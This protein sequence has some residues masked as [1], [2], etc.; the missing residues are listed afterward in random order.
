MGAPSPLIPSAHLDGLSYAPVLHDAPEVAVEVGRGVVGA[1]PDHVAVEVAPALAAAFERAVLRLPLCSA[2]TFDDGEGHTFAQ[3]VHPACPLAEAVR[4]AADAGATWHAVD[5]DLPLDVPHDDRLPDPYAVRH[6]GLAGLYRL[7][8]SQAPPPAPEP[9]DAIREAVMADRLRRLV[10]QGPTV[11]V[12]GWLHVAGI[13]RALAEHTPIPVHRARV[14]APLVLHLHPD[15]LA[16]VLPH[17]PLLDALVELRR[18]LPP[19]LPV[20]PG[21]GAP[22]PAAHAGLVVL[23]G[24]RGAARDDR[25]EAFR[26][27]A[28]DHRCVDE[29]YTGVD[30]WRV[31][32]A[33]VDEA[34]R[35]YERL[36]DAP[37]A[38]WQRRGLD[39]MLAKLAAFEG[40]LLPD[41]F[42][43]LAAARGA[44]DDDFAWGL[45]RLADIHPWQPEEAEIPTTHLHAADLRLGSRTIRLERDL[46]RTIRRL[47]RFP[48]RRRPTSDE[49]GAWEAGFDDPHLVSWPPEDLTIEG[50]ATE[51]KRKGAGFLEA[52]EARVEPFTASLRDG[53]DLRETLRHVEDPRPWVREVVRHQG[54]ADAV[55]LIFARE[56]QAGHYPYRMTWLGEHQNESDMSF[57]STPP[58]ARIIGPGIARCE[59]G[60][61]MMIV[62]P[63]QLYDVWRIPEYRRITE[64][65]DEILTLAAL[66]YT[67]RRNVIHVAAQ[68]PSARLQAIARGLGRRLVHLP[69]GRFDPERIRRLR[70]FHILSG[71]ARRK[72]ARA[73]I[74]GVFRAR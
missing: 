61:L 11:A 41:L 46:R 57:Y 21:A 31:L 7:W 2:L 37:V 14:K 9:V 30:R 47:Q 73:Y 72:D 3:L 28:E 5:A 50:F 49:P 67:R 22:E 68:P 58:G 19:E 69:L 1:G 44:V 33:L 23:S 29:A 39:T 65:P 4:A 71:R 74:R 8:A 66:D 17:A 63:M 26:R 13:E 53:F 36:T 10:A 34:E 20:A 56:D 25:G 38:A 43:L 18:S 32:R 55:V 40:R 62:P 64:H 35:A 45:L 48:V 6:L 15:S 59:Y 42:S 27:I 24:G 52:D 54:D 51:L 16:E 12:V 60:G 70:T